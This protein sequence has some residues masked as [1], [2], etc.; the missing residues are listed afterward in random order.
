[1][2]A[3]A[4]LADPVRG[5]HLGTLAF[6]AS[7]AS[8]VGC[9]RKL[10]EDAWLDRSEVGLWA[11]ADG[12]GGHAA[13]D[14]ASREV[15]RSLD[16]VSDFASAFAFRRNVR[17]SLFH[18]NAVL[19]RMAIREM[20]DAVGSTVVT[21]IAHGGHYACTWAGDSRAYL[22]RAGV[23]TRITTDHTLAQELL[24]TGRQSE[25][26]ARSIPNA[27]VITR[28]VGARQTLELDGVYGRIEPGDRFLLCSDGLFSVLSDDEIRDHLGPRSAKDAV[29]HLIRAALDNEV[30]DNVTCVVIDAA[31]MS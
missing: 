5:A 10:N 26:E 8:H 21:L 1:M 25:Q 18:A 12:V 14:V 3:L 6:Q 9:V 20:L 4:R 11:V 15:I 23:L 2:S 16:R 17:N 28:A 7:A 30:A 13:G 27:N 29:G 22:L 19:Q 31:A 24:S